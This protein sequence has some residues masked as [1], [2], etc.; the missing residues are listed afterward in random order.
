MAVAAAAGWGWA[1]EAATTGR[2]SAAAWGWTAETAAAGGWGSAAGRWS[3]KAATAWGWATAARGWTAKT[4]AT[5][6]WAINDTTVRGLVC[7]CQEVVCE[8]YRHLGI[9]H[10]HRD[11][12]CQFWCH[13]GWRVGTARRWAY[14][15]TSAWRWPA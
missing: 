5:G 4:A 8:R 7:R 11:K 15:S 10:R 13:L 1:T 9:G 12:G 6:G 3:A 2:W 14:G